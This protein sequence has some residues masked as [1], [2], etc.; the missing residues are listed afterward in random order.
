M[1]VDYF[2]EARLELKSS[3][4]GSSGRKEKNSSHSSNTNSC[5][6]MS[7][8]AKKTEQKNKNNRQNVAARSSRAPPKGKLVKKQKLSKEDARGLRR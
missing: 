7:L 3:S 8:D 4:L 2:D 5:M 1:I 6:E